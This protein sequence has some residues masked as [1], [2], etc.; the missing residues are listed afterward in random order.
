MKIATLYKM[1]SLNLMIVV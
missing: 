1:K